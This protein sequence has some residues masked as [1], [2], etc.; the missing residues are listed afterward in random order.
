[1]LPKRNIG[2]AK[3][4]KFNYMCVCVCVCVCV[5]PRDINLTENNISLAKKKYRF[6]QEIELSK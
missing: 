6:S 1:M 5:L 2:L 3:R 4:N